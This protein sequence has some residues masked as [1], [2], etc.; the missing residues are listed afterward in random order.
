[1]ISEEE[2]RIDESTRQLPIGSEEVVVQRK[3]KCVSISKLVFV[4]YRVS[5]DNY[6]VV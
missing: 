1:M 2:A 4:N 6:L 5:N 3:E